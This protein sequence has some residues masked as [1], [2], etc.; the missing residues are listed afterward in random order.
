MN[1]WV[2]KGSEFSILVWICIIKFSFSKKGNKEQSLVLVLK[3]LEL[4]V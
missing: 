3:I 4:L 2:W 1:Q